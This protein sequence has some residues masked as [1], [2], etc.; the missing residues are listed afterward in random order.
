M[1][2]KNDIGGGKLEMLS[3]GLFPFKP[4]PGGR[5]ENTRVAFP[6]QIVDSR[7]EFISFPPLS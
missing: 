3:H 2:W 5:L 6:A 7:G 4:M 1:S